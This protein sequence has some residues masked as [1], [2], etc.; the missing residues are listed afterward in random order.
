M[1]TNC[2]RGT[3]QGTVSRD[4]SKPKTNRRIRSEG[5]FFSKSNW[6][7]TNRLAIHFGLVLE[8]EV[9]GQDDYPLPN[10]SRTSRTP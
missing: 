8:P 7:G 6:N 10:P 4:R 1:L 9:D 5:R 2:A 3:G